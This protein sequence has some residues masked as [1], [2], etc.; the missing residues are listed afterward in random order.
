VQ[1]AVIICL[2]ISPPVY[3]GFNFMKGS[4]ETETEKEFNPGNK[5]II[6]IRPRNAQEIPA[7]IFTFFIVLLI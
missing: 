4:F 5:M 3:L 7:N 2:A 6:R 1:L